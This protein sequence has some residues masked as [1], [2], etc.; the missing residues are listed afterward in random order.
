MTLKRKDEEIQGFAL[1][2]GKDWYFDVEI[3]TTNAKYKGFPAMGYQGG[4]AS[5]FFIQLPIDAFG[6]WKKGQC[7]L[8][9]KAISNL[10]ET[11]WTMQHKKV[12]NQYDRS[13]MGDRLTWGNNQIY[14][15]HYTHY[16]YGFNINDD[17]TCITEISVSGRPE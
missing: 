7:V 1:A 10:L 5:Q 17:A 4:A 15:K 16:L 2:A 8:A 14:I 9:G 6:D 11:G 3:N 13:M 12:W